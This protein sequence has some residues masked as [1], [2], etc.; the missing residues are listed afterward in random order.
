[1]SIKIGKAKHGN[2]QQSTLKNYFKLKDGDNVYRI[3][4]PI[5]ELADSG[6]WSAYLSVHYGYKNSEGKLKPFQSTEVVNRKTKMVEVPDAASDRL[7]NLKLQLDAAKAAGD[8]KKAKVLSEMLEQY[9]LDKKHYMNVMTLDGKIG[10]LKIPHKAKLAL[11]IAI[12][13]LESEGVDPI[14]VEDGR[15]FKFSRS[16]S[17]LDTV[18]QVSIYKEKIKVEGVGNVEKE[19]VHSLTDAMINRLSSEASLN[20]TK[21]A[22]VITSAQVEAIV[23]GDIQKDFT[24][25]DSIFPKSSR[26]QEA[27]EESVQE[28]IEEIAQAVVSQPKTATTVKVAATSSPKSEEKTASEMSEEEKEAYL[29]SL[30]L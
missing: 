29:K 26:N 20:L 10:I 21:L 28:D 1:M 24:A 23:K 6:K 22:P 2:S 5:G 4:P 19:L 12:K 14:S 27:S 7:K 25:I 30:G 15:F 11:D 3:L 8:A 17:G 13:G 16:G 9:N 18:H